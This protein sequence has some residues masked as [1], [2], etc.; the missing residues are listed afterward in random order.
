MCFGGCI[1]KWS[2]AKV[3]LNAC[4]DVKDGRNVNGEQL[5]AS[6]MD[7]SDSLFEY[8]SIFLI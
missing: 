5:A 3:R 7:Y 6:L 4:A 8:F 2:E 1:A